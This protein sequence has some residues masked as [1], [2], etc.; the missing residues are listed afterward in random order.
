MTD[1]ARTG[2]CLCGAVRY[3]LS[4]APRT[5]GACHCRMCR[6]FSGGIELGVEV[7]PDGV[8]WEGEDRIRTF[9]SSEWAER[10]FCDICGSSL[11]WR[12]IAP[13]PM[14]GLLSLS[15]GSLDSLEGLDFDIE[16]YIDHKPTTY[17]FA[18]ERRQM[19][20]AQILEMVRAGGEDA[21]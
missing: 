8:A 3:T 12:L 18:G 21:P 15:A 6:R 1:T 13:G 5:Y 19:T 7:R 17:A 11:F 14:Q 2:G 4:E 20:E 16:V 10:G 9:K